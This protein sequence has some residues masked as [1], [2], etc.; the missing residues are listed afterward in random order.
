M[1]IPSSLPF[2]FVVHRVGFGQ[3]MRHSPPMRTCIRQNA[4]ICV[5]CS[6]VD[7][8]GVLVLNYLLYFNGGM[9]FFL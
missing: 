7:L 4:L 2:F 6:I 8:C 3:A 9:E 1:H 5:F